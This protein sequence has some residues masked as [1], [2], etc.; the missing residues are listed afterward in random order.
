MIQLLFVLQNP[1]KRWK[2][3]DYKSVLIKT[4]NFSK[5]KAISIG[6]A[7]PN[8]QDLVMFDFEISHAVSHAGIRLC[9]GILGAEFEL[10]FND[11]RHWDHQNNTWE[12]SSQSE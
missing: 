9:V 3:R 6:Y 5:N 7:T 2:S 10:E 11:N 4:F 1:F 12:T 8:F